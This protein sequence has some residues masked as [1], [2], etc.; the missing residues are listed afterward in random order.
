[1]G[2][3]A[4][5]LL[6]EAKAETDLPLCVEVLS[7]THL[8]LYEHIDILQVGARNMDHY[9]LLKAVG[10]M[11]KP[12][13]LKRNPQ[14]TLE[15]FLLAAEYVLLYGAPMVLLCERGIRT[16]ERRLRYT[17]DVGAIA[18]LRSEIPWPVIADPSHAAGE[19]AY[20]QP[21]ALAAIGA[22]AE[23]LIVEVH[24]QPHQALSDAQQ[25]LSIEAFAHLMEKVERVWATQRDLASPTPT[26]KAAS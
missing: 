23:G 18:V 7:E 22:G 5:D 25:Q 17:L 2:A 12:I 16:F 24:P 26:A 1:L 6:L 13:L 8:L 14:A 4:I 20:V 15:E 3:E 21:L 11:Q 9:E 19:A 10:Q